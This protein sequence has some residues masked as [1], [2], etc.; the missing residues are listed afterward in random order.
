MD[1]AE[2]GEYADGRTFELPNGWQRP[3]RAALDT[4]LRKAVSALEGSTALS[5]LRRYYDQHGNYAG[6]LL[7]TLEPNP[8]D[9]LSPADLLAVA[10][11]S[12]RIQPLQARTLLDSTSGGRVQSIRSL[13]AIPFGLPITS[14]DATD[15]N[16]PRLLDQ[17]WDLHD[18]FRT[19]MSGQVASTNRW[20]FA[21]K[22]CA[23]KRPYLFPVRDNEVCCYLGDVARLSSSGMGQF[24]HDVQVFAFLM[25]HQDVAGQ[26]SELRRALEAEQYRLDASDLRLLDAALWMA[27]T[28][29]GRVEA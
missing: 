8:A 23:R 3:G 19:A 17:M 4:A 5:R 21:A 26:L 14:L 11:L 7:T 24:S 28:N 10:M 18:G 20:V 29:G 22:L 16:A 27:A 6:D 9:D 12:M 1:M 15:V 2:R 13:R 25:S